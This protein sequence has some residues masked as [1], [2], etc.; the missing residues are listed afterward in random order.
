[1]EHKAVKWRNTEGGWWWHFY[2][3]CWWRCWAAEFR[4]NISIFT[5]CQCTQTNNTQVYIV[6]VFERNVLR[7]SNVWE[8]WTSSI[9][10]EAYRRVVHRPLQQFR[11]TIKIVKYSSCIVTVL[12][13]RTVVTVAIAH[14]ELSTVV[15]CA[16]DRR[17]SWRVARDQVFREKKPCPFP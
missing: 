15:I 9:E 7:K 14:S 6:L 4:G 5:A 12:S 1:L 17:A 13:V 16:D 10:Q 8:P 2:A 3:A 11:R